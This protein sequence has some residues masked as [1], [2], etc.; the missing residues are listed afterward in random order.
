MHGGVPGCLAGGIATWADVV[1]GA[2]VAA[3]ESEAGARVEHVFVG[4]VGFGGGEWIGGWQL[5]IEGER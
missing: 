5:G 3:V 2:D 1:H 4:W